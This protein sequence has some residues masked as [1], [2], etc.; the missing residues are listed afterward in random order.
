MQPTDA[1][2]VSASS[3]GMIVEL[4][5]VN[6]AV[7]TESEFEKSTAKDLCKLD[8]LLSFASSPI[9]FADLSAGKIPPS[10]SGAS[11]DKIEIP[12]LSSETLK[13]NFDFEKV[14]QLSSH[15]AC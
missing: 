1:E 7:S 11:N 8:N 12:G 15:Q 9:A 3:V 14:R 10:L 4:V 13:E 6:K 5:L 2:L